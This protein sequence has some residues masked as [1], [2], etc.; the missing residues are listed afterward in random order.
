MSRLLFG[1]TTVVEDVRLLCLRSRLIGVYAAVGVGDTAGVSRKMLLNCSVR[2]CI[3]IALAE[4]AC[5][6]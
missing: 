5:S 3:S 4:L 6:T 1:L 2:D